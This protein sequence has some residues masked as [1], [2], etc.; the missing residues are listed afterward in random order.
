MRAGNRLPLPL[1]SGPRPSPS[2]DLLRLPL[3]GRF[4]RWR[5]ARPVLQVPLL[6]LAVVVIVDGLRGPRAGPMNLAGVLPWVHWRGLVVLG[7]LVGGNGFCIACRVTLPATMAATS[8]SASDTARPRATFGPAPAAPGAPLCAELFPSRAGR[9]GRRPDL[10]AL[11]FVQVFGAVA[12][13]AGMVAPVV[14]WQERLG[15]PL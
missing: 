15:P 14:A 8:D 10:A 11:A 12:N 7:L 2:F 3:L 1:L 13:A 5:Y 6:L 4:L 9:L